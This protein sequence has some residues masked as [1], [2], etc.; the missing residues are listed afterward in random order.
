M[1]AFQKFLAEIGLEFTTERVTDSLIKMGQGMVAIFVIIGVI[2][3]ATMLTNKIFS[4]K[5]NK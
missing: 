4:G 1:N 3:G 5:K 2:I